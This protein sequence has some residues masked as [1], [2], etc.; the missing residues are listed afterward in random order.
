MIPISVLGFLTILGFLVI[1]LGTRISAIS[2][3]ILVPTIT[4]L[5]GGFSTEIGRFAIDGIKTVAPVAAMIMFAVLYFGLMLD[6]GLFEPLIQRVIAMVKADPVRLCIASAILPMLVALDGDGATTFL[7]SITALLPIH[8]RLGIR[9]L[10][11]PCIVALAAGVMNMLPWGGPT[12]RAMSV[13]NA[14]VGDIFTPMVPAMLGGIVWVFLVAWMMGRAERKRL[15]G[16]VPI[17]ADETLPPPTSGAGWRFWFNLSLTVLLVLLLFRDI[18]VS[19]M[20]LPPLP[21]PLL[22]M[23]AYALALPVNL[24]SAHDQA[25]HI[26]RH[27]P[28]VTNVVSMIFAAGLFT[29]IL[30]GTGMTKAMAVDLAGLVPHTLS[31]WL[32]TMI[33]ITGMPMS[34]ILPPDAYYFGVLPVF[35]KTAASLGLDPNVVG[36]GAILGQMTTGFP[37]SPL[38]AS[39]FILVGMTGVSL[40]DHQRFTFK[41][42]L[43][44]TIVMTILGNVCGAL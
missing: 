22:F 40:R 35:A 12:A 17:P 20:P 34:L 18:Y 4:A 36:R 42:A 29:G 31:P 27:S 2:A 10:V 39:T 11:L 1:V 23:A 43:G 30:N 13:L 38:T 33:A 32:G 41:W 19:L 8:R 16:G 26:G 9:P 21:A 44:T 15:A 6:R 25:E 24:T 37:L 7:I 14:D 28:A 5:V 3:L